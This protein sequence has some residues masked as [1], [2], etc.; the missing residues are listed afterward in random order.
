MSKKQTKLATT[1]S[2]LCCFAFIFSN[3]SSCEVGL[4]SS[5]DTEAPEITIVSPSVGSIIRDK[6]ALSGRWGDDGSVADIWVT[7]KRTDGKTGEW[8]ISGSDVSWEQDQNDI[9]QGNWKAIVDPTAKGLIDGP[10]QAIVHIKDNN[11]HK[12]TQ[13]TSFTIDNTPPILILSR[14]GTTI[15]SIDFDSYGKKITLEGKATDDND[16]GL[17]ELSVYKTAEC[18]EEDFL[19]TYTLQNV[20]LT[21]ETDAAE[22]G[23]LEDGVDKYDKVYRSDLSGSPDKDTNGTANRYFKIKVYDG[24]ER[25]PISDSD[26][27]EDDEKGNCAD[28]YYT[29]DGI[30]DALVA[31]KKITNLYHIQNGTL[32]TTNTVITEGLENAKVETGKFSVN[33]KNNPTF[34][35]NSRNA[36]AAPYTSLDDPDFQVTNGNSYLEVE[37]SPG[38]DKKPIK[39]S[40]VAVGLRECNSVGEFIAGSPVIYLISEG[41]EEAGS[42]TDVKIT[43]TGT[44]YKFKTTKQIGKNNYTDLN[45]GRYYR[46]VVEG[47][48]TT[49]NSIEE[50]GNFSFKL[51]ATN[52]KIELS[53]QGVP[54]YISQDSAAWTGSHA[55]FNAEL[56]WNGGEPPYYIYRDNNTTPITVNSQTADSRQLGSNR[57]I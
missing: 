13:S 15:D 21:V 37:V 11:G 56:T 41:H 29:D 9:Q 20:P 4:G 34:I 32:E 38:L 40:T 25:I 6:F 53:G 31:A 16:V 22:Q 52:E 14:P 1:F 33:P 51:I 3:F 49:G 27:L 42:Y 19:Y 35:V 28:Y 55:K 12:I 48:D 5:V 46:V 54:E 45:T 36:F 30:A 8:T 50:T 39:V 10:Y 23:K 44:S 7:L 18:N 17:I 57:R 24:A 26:A 2:I 43:K 47:R